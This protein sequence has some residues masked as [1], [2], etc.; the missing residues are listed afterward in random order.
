MRRFGSPLARHTRTLTQ[1]GC[2][3]DALSPGLPGTI[4]LSWAVHGIRIVRS[5]GVHI[6]C[7]E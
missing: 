4:A 7:L 3:P 5:R 6:C 1:I 2:S